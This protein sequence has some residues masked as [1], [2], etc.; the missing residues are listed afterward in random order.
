VRALF[1][2]LHV[3]DVIE[4]DED[5]AITGECCHLRIQVGAEAEGGIEGD[6]GERGHGL[7]EGGRDVNRDQIRLAPEDLG[8][9]MPEI[10]D[11]AGAVL[12]VPHHA[13]EVGA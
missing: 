1:P 3:L 9:G 13:R 12:R 8:R 11:E 10:L 4:I 5:R 2:E 7:L 6:C